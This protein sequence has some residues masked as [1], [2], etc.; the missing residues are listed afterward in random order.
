MQSKKKNANINAMETIELQHLKC[1]S[2]YIFKLDDG[3][4]V[5]RKG[6]WLMTCSSGHWKMD[7]RKA[8]MVVAYKKI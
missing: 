6:S 1:D 4:E 5:R 8:R 7:T 3:R 2:N